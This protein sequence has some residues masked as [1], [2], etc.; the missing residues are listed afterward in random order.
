MRRYRAGIVAIARDENPYLL[1]WLAYHLAIGFQH[2]WVYDNESVTP[3][4]RT[5]SRAAARGHVTVVRWPTPANGKTQIEAYNHFLRHHGH[6]VS[7]A[8]VIDLDEMICLKRDRTIA[9][10]LDRFD[11]ATG[12]A[13][14]WRF[15][16][17]S[18]HRAHEPGLMMERF[19]RAAPADS[20]VNAGVKS[21]HRLDAVAFLLPHY[22][23]YRDTEVVVSAS[24]APVPNDWR[25]PPDPANLALAQVNHYFVKSAAEWERKIRRHNG[26]SADDR[27]G[28]FARLDRNE[29][30][31]ASILAHLDATRSWMRRLARRPGLRHRLADAAGAAADATRDLLR[32][33]LPRRG[34]G[35]RRARPVDRPA[36]EAGRP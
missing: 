35:P 26:Y 17:S 5:L 36:R 22:A 7:W 12:I 15:F 4:S 8:A 10:F 2:I 13:L 27:E 25:I 33:I 32:R 31:D 24:G 20:P 23:L 34:A 28:Y 19:R 14:N 16:G 21:L 11:A 29:V 9:D 3:L 1:E 30:E 18:G 6:A